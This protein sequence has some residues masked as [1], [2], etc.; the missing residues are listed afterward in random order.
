MSTHFDEPDA[1]P[2]RPSIPGLELKNEPIEF[3]CR[4]IWGADEVGELL[5]CR[6]SMECTVRD[7]GA[8]F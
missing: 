1:L 5:A 4:I 3:H 7:V 8:E 6:G 2:A